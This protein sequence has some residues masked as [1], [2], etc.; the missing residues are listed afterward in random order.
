[1]YRH[2]IFCK[3]LPVVFKPYGIFFGAGPAHRVREQEP[4]DK[5]GG[6]NYQVVTK[7]EKERKKHLDN[8]IETVRFFSSGRGSGAGQSEN[9]S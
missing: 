6:E 7:I 1:M 5:R 2:E 3:L 9:I 8:G 4:G